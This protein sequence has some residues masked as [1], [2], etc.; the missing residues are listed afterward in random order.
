M[1]VNANDDLVVNEPTCG[2][3]VAAKCKIDTIIRDLVASDR[4]DHI[5]KEGPDPVYANWRRMPTAKAG[6]PRLGHSRDAA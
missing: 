1:E 4:I 3:D 6:S 2:I 5:R